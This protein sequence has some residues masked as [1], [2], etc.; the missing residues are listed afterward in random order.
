MFIFLDGISHQTHFSEPSTAKGDVVAQRECWRTSGAGTDERGSR[1]EEESAA[2]G[3]PW[4]STKN[5]PSHPGQ[6]VNTIISLDLLFLHI[7]RTVYDDVAFMQT[8]H[9]GLDCPA[10]TPM[11]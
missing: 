2:S 3:G 4:G 5:V 1:A 8:R 9:F 11:P 7:Q 6:Q 10:S